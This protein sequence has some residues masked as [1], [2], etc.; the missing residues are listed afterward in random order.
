MFWDIF[1]KNIKKHNLEYAHSNLYEAHIGYNFLRK[2]KN[3]LE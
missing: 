1:K 3:F 2:N